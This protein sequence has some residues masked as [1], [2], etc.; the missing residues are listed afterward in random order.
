MRARDLESAWDELTGM[1]Q[2]GLDAALAA[3]AKP[4]KLTQVQQ[5]DQPIGASAAVNGHASSSDPGSDATIPAAPADAP[6]QA[7]AAPAQTVATLAQTAAASGEATAASA[8]TAVAPVQT[9]AGLAQTAAS[10]AQTAAGPVQTASALDQV[11]TSLVNG[12]DSCPALSKQSSQRQQENQAAN[13]QH[14]QG[15]NPCSHLV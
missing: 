2:A 12:Y 8:Q 1:Q 11:D 10:P 4:R 14:A 7:A 9:A 15:S 5:P 6:V 13:R 3:K